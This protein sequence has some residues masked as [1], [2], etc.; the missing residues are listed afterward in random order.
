MCKYDHFPVSNHN[1]DS[2]TSGTEKSLAESHTE[3]AIDP[4]NTDSEFLVVDDEQGS[5]ENEGDGTK[6]E[7]EGKEKVGGEK[8]NEK[9]EDQ[10][11]EELEKVE[12]DEK[13]KDDGKNEDDE[14]VKDNEKKED[15]GEIE[16]KKKIEDEKEEDKNVVKLTPKMNT[17]KVESVIRS[18]I[19][20]DKTLRG[21]LSGTCY[22][23][24]PFGLI[25]GDGI[26]LLVPLSD[27]IINSDDKEVKP[28]PAVVD[29][30]MEESGK[31][32]K[33]KI[34]K[35]NKLQIELKIET[36]KRNIIYI[37]E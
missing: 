18:R 16:D 29:D 36:T 11:K 4:N 23:W 25:V 22:T 9:K 5:E 34:K 33:K 13:V 2:T 21:S 20:L 8:A 32:K 19:F 26:S 6:T 27:F 31:E 37:L 15:K 35:L 3:T 10:K 1:D 24:E 28:F 17:S 14:K 30:A 7:D 12:D